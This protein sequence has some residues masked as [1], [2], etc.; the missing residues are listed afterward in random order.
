MLWGIKYTLHIII[1]ATHY[2]VAAVHT[3]YS[4]SPKGGREGGIHVTGCPPSFPGLII[5]LDVVIGMH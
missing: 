5:L 2:Y 3:S 1:I 4:D